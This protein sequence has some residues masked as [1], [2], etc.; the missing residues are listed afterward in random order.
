MC[1]DVASKHA[2]LHICMYLFPKT[3]T[4]HVRIHMHCTSC[5]PGLRHK[6][7]SIDEDTLKMLC[8]DGGQPAHE[9]IMT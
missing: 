5:S 9:M 7:R 2:H 8:I 3:H 4:T 6:W 1:A